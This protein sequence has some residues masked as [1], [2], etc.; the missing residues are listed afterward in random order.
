VA[1]RRRVGMTLVFVVTSVVT[2]LAHEVWSEFFGCPLAIN[3]IDRER[4]AHL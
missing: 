2:T 4:R 3:G 1:R